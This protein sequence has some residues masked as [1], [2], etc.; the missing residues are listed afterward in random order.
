MPQR[1][2]QRIYVTLK[3]AF[4]TLA[5]QRMGFVQSGSTMV[6]RGMCRS[7]LARATSLDGQSWRVTPLV[8]NWRPGGRR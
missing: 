7:E 1:R 8:R 5:L 2:D 6:R 4:S 3:R